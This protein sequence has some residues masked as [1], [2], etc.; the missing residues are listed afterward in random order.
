MN[1][2]S[3]QLQ[4]NSYNAWTSPSYKVCRITKFVVNKDEQGCNSGSRVSSLSKKASSKGREIRSKTWL[5]P[6]G[7]PPLNR[8]YFWVNS[9]CEQWKLTVKI[10]S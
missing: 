5:D 1:T 9:T 4:V 3:Q 6:K 7:Q 10:E 2:K 8:Q